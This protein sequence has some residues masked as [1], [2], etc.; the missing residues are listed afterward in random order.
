MREQIKR[1]R[2]LVKNQR[3]PLVER[4]LDRVNAQEEIRQLGIV[5]EDRQRFGGL[6]LALAA[7]ARGGGLGV[8]DGFGGLAVGGGLDFLR[9]GFAFVLLRG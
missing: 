4:L 7:D 3:R 5:L 6:G 2:A 9:L 8:G 1:R